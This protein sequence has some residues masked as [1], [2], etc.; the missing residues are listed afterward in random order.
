MKISFS[1]VTAQGIN[2]ELGRNNSLEFSGILKKKDPFLVK[3]QGTIKGEIKYICDRCGDEFMLPVDQN[4]EL[5]LSD[6]VY[7]DR[8][9]ELSDTV[10]F[11]D[12][13][14]DLI[15]VFESE[16][17]AFK[18]DYFYCEKCKNL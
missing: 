17:E 3:C 14:I 16:I 7:K 6:G 4:V 12:G 15:E 2:F 8:E 9:N 5:N 11:F 1:K 10:E 13:N 18:S